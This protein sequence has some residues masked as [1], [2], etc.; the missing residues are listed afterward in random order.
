MGELME[1]E[2]AE[3]VGE[4]GKHNIISRCAYSPRD[5]GAVVMLGGHAGA[6]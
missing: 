2:I 5:R 4:K 6:L 1:A 3:L